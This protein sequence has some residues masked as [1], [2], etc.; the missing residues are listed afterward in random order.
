[1]A[2]SI[3]IVDDHAMIRMLLK[4]HLHQQA[5]FTVVG[6]AEDGE[7]GI[8]KAEL[9]GPDVILMD[10]AMPGMDGIEATRQICQR[11]PGAKVLILTL[12]ASSENCS[13]ALQSGALGYILKDSADEEV[14]TAIRTIATG[15]HYFG[16]GV[17]NP[18]ESLTAEA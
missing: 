10:V 9:L 12:Y 14:V 3:L 6:E 8:A 11:I 2:I 18:L 7:E 16:D 13:R 17:T 5:D 4:R 1:M 15:E